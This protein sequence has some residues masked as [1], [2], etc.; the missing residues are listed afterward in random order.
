MINQSI[1]ATRPSVGLWPIMTS[2]TSM[3]YDQSFGHFKFVGSYDFGHI[4]ITNKIAVQKK[5][6]FIIKSIWKSVAMSYKI[7]TH[8]FYYRIHMKK[9]IAMSYKIA[10]HFFIIKSI[11]KSASWYYITPRTFS[12]RFYN[13]KVHCDIIWQR[14]A[15]VHIDFIIKK[16]CDIIWH[17]DALFNMDFIIKK[18]VAILYD[19]ATHFFIWIL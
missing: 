16:C 6:F 11:W 17:R 1:S 12:Y 5:V 2:M 18:C 9:C 14:H 10:T 7:A 13:K 15:L 8:F 3:T 19:I 4:V